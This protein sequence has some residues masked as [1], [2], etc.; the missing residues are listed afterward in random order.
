MKESPKD[1]GRLWGWLVYPEDYAS[2]DEIK[3]LCAD[4]HIPMMMSPVHKPEK[5]CEKEHIHCM[6]VL[7]GNQTRKAMLEAL[8]GFHVKHV[9]KIV[10][11]IGYERYLCHLDDVD[12]I[13]YDPTDITCFGGAYP[14]FALEK[15]YRDGFVMV[16]KLIEQMGITVYADLASLVA[17]DYPELIESLNR[18]SAHF[19][20][21]CRSRFELAK[22]G[23]NVTYVKSRRSFGYFF[24]KE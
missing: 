5:G 7:N 10:S 6:C 17:F 12:K 22:W 20:N 3:Q 9:E 14:A 4:L 1:A 21:V 18:Y 15:E 13:Q 24:D 2:M 23:N 8:E 19:N 11:R 16:S